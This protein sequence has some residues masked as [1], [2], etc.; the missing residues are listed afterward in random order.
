MPAAQN[1]RMV[2]ISFFLSPQF[3]LDK[4]DETEFDPVRRML[5]K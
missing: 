1:R 3:P 2:S 5:F 4:A